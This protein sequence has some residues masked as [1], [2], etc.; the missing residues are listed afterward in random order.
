MQIKNN[1]VYSLAQR[2]FW[3]HLGYMYLDDENL[4]FKALINYFG[5]ISQQWHLRHLRSA[6]CRS[7]WW[8]ANL[9]FTTV[10]GDS[11][12]FLVTPAFGEYVSDI[13]QKQ[14]LR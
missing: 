13:I 3:A 9:H 4:T 14:G 6:N 11:Y 2:C 1:A 12:Q 5:L 10:N 7:G 8:A